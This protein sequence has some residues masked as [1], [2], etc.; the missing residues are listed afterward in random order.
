MQ[1]RVG[2]GG[3]ARNRRVRSHLE[4]ASATTV[5]STAFRSAFHNG[6]GMQSLGARF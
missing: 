6:C 3:A 1:K 5:A 2:L 4:S